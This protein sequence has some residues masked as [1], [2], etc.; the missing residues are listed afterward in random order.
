MYH[1]WVKLDVDIIGWQNIEPQAG[2]LNTFVGDFLTLSEYT[3]RCNF[4]D[5]YFNTV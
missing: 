3:A 4:N 2:G 1:A 5:V